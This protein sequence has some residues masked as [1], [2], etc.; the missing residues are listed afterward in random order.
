[1]EQNLKSVVMIGVMKGK[2]DM[3]KSVAMNGV[4]SGKFGKSENCENDEETRSQSEERLCKSIIR[5]LVKR[6][7]EKAHDVGRFG[8]KTRTKCHML[9]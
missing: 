2:G 6:N 1:M 9:R 8:R 4:N 3:V 7:H 5:G